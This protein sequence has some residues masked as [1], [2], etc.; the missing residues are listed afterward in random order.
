M[1]HQLVTATAIELTKLPLRE[2]VPVRAARA[3]ALKNCLAVVSAVNQTVEVELGEVSRSCIARSQNAVRR[4]LELIDEDLTY[5]GVARDSR[6]S[7]FVTAE[8]VFE[9]V[10][11]RLEDFAHARRV[12]IEFRVG[13]GGLWGDRKALIEAL[14]NIVKNAV[15]SSS[16]GDTV[17]V[18]S[19]EGAEDGQLWTVSDSGPGIPRDVLPRLGAPFVS[20]KDGGTGLGIAVARD[21]VGN[22]GGLLQVESDPGVGT[23]VSI[24]VPP[25]PTL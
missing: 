23:T 1:T 24:W 16:V 6:G 13:P 15:E 25:L 17:T 3:H 22:H 9:Q 21:I 2:E 8:Q 14:A 4:L 7:E 11:L 19:A 5:N 10:C 12:R 20:R 18:A